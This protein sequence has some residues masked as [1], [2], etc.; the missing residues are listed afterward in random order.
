MEVNHKLIGQRINDMRLA[1]GITQQVLAEEVELSAGQIS[2]IERARKKVSLDS[3]IKIAN[4]LNVTV[5]ELLT[6]NLEHYPTA[7]QSDIDDLL[8]CCCTKERKIVYEIIREIIVV[9][10][11]NQ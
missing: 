5:D 7:Y 8:H 4:A 10:R 6:G 3:L 11:N 9:L 2:H 1:L